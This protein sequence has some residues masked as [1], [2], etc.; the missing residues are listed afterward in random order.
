MIV[1]DSLVVTGVFRALSLGHF[2]NLLRFSSTVALA[3]VLSVMVAL[4]YRTESESEQEEE[5][6]GLMKA[7]KYGH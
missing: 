1:R 2:A 3:V 5:L 4:Q 6:S 7:L